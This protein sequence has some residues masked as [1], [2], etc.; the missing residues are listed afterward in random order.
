MP[1]PSAISPEP[2]ASTAGSAATRSAAVRRIDP[3]GP[4]ARRPCG[5]RR[6]CRLAIR[7]PGMDQAAQVSRGAGRRRFGRRADPSGSHVEC[8]EETAPTQG[9]AYP[10]GPVHS[11][12]GAPAGLGCDPRFGRGVRTA[13]PVK[14]FTISIS[15][16][17]VAAVQVLLGVTYAGWTTTLILQAVR[18]DLVDPVGSFTDFRRWFLRPCSA[19]SSLDGASCWP[20]WPSPLRWR[21]RRSGWP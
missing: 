12:R 13:W 3:Q 11:R 14:I 4:P 2:P 16:S 10:P 21:R 6:S 19:R 8:G 1:D 7:L 20:A 9:P 17:L 5:D 18:H 15:L